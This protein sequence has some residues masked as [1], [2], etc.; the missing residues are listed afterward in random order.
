M[1]ILRHLR[2]IVSLYLVGYEIVHIRSEKGPLN[3]IHTEVV[4]NTVQ[5]AF[6]GAEVISESEEEITFQTFLDLSC[7][8]VELALRRISALTS[9][10]GEDLILALINRDEEKVSTIIDSDRE[11][12]RFNFYIIRQ[13]KVSIHDDRLINRIGLRKQKECLGYRIETKNVEKIA[14]SIVSIAEKLLNL[15]GLTINSQI[16]LKISGSI[17]TLI[18]LLNKVMDAH[19]RREYILADKVVS[20]VFEAKINFDRLLY[21]I[22]DSI[23]DPRVQFELVGMVTSLEKIANY[24]G[25]I[26][27]VILNRTIED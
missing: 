16:L 14:D 25:E 2:K 27:E 12:N 6:L 10:M 1:I 4:K 19:F 20:K 23:S 22:L 26:A 17:S 5:K 21:L 24:C 7:F 9:S 18:N 15:R 13:L 11:V 8:A 3:P